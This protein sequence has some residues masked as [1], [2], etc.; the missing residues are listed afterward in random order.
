[1]NTAVLICLLANGSTVYL[2][3]RFLLKNG[4]DKKSLLLNRLRDKT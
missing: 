4:V 1:M 2:H 3:I